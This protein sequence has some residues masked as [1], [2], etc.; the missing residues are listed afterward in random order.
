VD[1]NAIG[2]VAAAA[3]KSAKKPAEKTEKAEKT[4]PAESFEKSSP[5]KSETV[6]MTYLPQ[7]PGILPVAIGEMPAP[8]ENLKNDR[9]KVSVPQNFPKPKPD[10]NGNFIFRTDDPRFDSVNS[11]FIANRA[12]EIAETYA[13][14]QIPW[15]FEKE[16]GRTELLVHPHAGQNEANAYYMSEAGS[17]NFFSYKDEGTGEFHRTGM[18]SDV[19][20]HETGH[21]I[22]DALRPLYMQ[23]L[24]VA[25]GGF[26]ESFGD[27]IALLTALSDPNV[28]EE[29]RRTTKGDMTQPNLASGAAEQLGRSSY[30]TNALREAV[31]D[32]KYADQHFLPYYDKENPGSGLGTEAHAYS[33]LFTG[34][35]YEIFTKLHAKVSD[36]ADLTFTES[37]GVA[38]DVAGRMLLRAVEFSPVGDLSYR[39]M[40]LAFLKADMIDNGGANAELLI[41]TF[42]GRK[43]LTDEDL[44][45]FVEK[46]EKLPEVRW[47]RGLD[48]KENAEKFLDANREKLGL[49]KDVKFEFH[50]AFKNESGERFVQYKTSRD[51]N[52]DDPVYGT[53]EGSKV[54]VLGGHQLVFDK[55]GVL[56]ANN[57]DEVTDRELEDVKNNLKTAILMGA[58]AE[59]A[60]VDHKR[61]KNHVPRLHIQVTN[62]GSGPVVGRAP[63]IFC[64]GG[65]DHDHSHSH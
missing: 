26:H 16:L 3:R 5:E 54:R 18:Q 40:A 6:K 8:Q 59:G 1:L 63:V 10:E 30:E 23:S 45:E 25:S 61:G 65:H 49:P 15:S 13:G 7:D 62:D 34:A 57:Y 14:R 43:I 12:L 31:N 4:A 47:T 48:K 20:A 33:N 36:A 42:Q 17:I 22:L 60:D 28:L 2:K 44:A 29:V 58:V 11:Y 52:L 53:H 21:A 38:R 39:E 51:S 27:M 35:F 50:T 9:F 55:E 24:S 32:H 64:G 41:E 37:V 46:E 56:I 19:V